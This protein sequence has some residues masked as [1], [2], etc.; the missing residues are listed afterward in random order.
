MNNSQGENVDSQKP[1]AEIIQFPRSGKY[2]EST[3][4]E[5]IFDQFTLEEI[6]GFILHQFDADYFVNQ[7]RFQRFAKLCKL[8]DSEKMLKENLQQFIKYRK[9]HTPESPP[10]S[11]LASLKYNE[12]FVAASFPRWDRKDK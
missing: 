5:W 1:D 12:P 9:K 4:V 10:V 2:P 11:D 7:K 6:K 3:L 8:V